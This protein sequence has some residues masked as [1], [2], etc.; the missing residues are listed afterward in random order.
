MDLYI[1]ITDENG[2]ILRCVNIYQDGSDSEVANEIAND[3]LNDFDGAKECERSILKLSGNINWEA[4]DEQARDEQ[5][6]EHREANKGSPGSID[7]RF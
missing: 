7:P 6:R 2:D 5:A 1:T 4:R 3:L